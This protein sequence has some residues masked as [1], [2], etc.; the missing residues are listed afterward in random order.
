MLKCLTLLLTLNSCET[1]FS[2]P[3]T[4][5]SLNEFRTKNGLTTL[6]SDAR[7]TA[8]ARAHAEDMARRNALDHAGFSQRRIRA[9]NVSYGCKDTP[10]A[11]RQWAGS[12]G[13]RKNMLL[14]DIRSYGLAY[15]DS[16]SGRRYW[17]LELGD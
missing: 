8:L 11:I 10:C 4:A 13:H 16:R 9:E 5:T 14:R 3:E 7:L 2:K 6:R 1:V 12:S 17:A 15:A